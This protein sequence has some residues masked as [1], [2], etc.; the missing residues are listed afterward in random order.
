MGREKKRTI[1]YVKYVFVY[2]N[3]RNESTVVRQVANSN[4]RKI[5][6]KHVPQL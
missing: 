3:E 1:L 5:K 6:N 2:C 4:E